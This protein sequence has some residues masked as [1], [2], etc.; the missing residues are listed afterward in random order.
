[1]KDYRIVTNN[2]VLKIIMKDKIIKLT[3]LDREGVD[4][5]SKLLL[6]VYTPKMIEGYDIPQFGLEP[7]FHEIID[8]FYYEDMVIWGVKEQVDISL[9]EDE[10]P[11]YQVCWY[12][13]K[14]EL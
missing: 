7:D 3:L 10:E 11:E 9:P 6:E 14:G 1:M 4:V 2:D 12:F 8:S 13:D 5:G